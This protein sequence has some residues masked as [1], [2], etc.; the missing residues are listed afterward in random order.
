LKTCGFCSHFV[1]FLQVNFRQDYPL[2]T[3]SCAAYSLGKPERESRMGVRCAARHLEV[4][5]QDLAN[6][7][8][9]PDAFSAEC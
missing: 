7:V 3:T 9:K 4:G 8:V 2:G 1:L 5:R 6:F